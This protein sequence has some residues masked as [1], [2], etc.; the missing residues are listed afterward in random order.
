VDWSQ[1]PEARTAGHVLTHQL[2]EAG[3]QL[4]DVRA[5]FATAPT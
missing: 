3:K 4:L 1:R 2:V 5:I